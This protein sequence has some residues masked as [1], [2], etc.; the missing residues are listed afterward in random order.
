MRFLTPATLPSL[1][2]DPASGVAGD[3]YFNTTDNVQRIYT[4]TGWSYANELVMPYVFSGTLA[5]KTGVLRLY[6]NSD[7]A[8][9][10]Y[11]SDVYVS[12]A[13]TG[14]SA[15][16]GVRKN[17][18]AASITL[19]VAA[20]GNSASSTTKLSVAVGDYLTVD[21]S[22]VGSTVAGSDAQ[23]TILAAT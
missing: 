14:S 9:V 10:I 15:I 3:R 23:V 13:P 18:A 19:T 11:R 22:Q 16:F 1:A 5:T 12:T 17:G 20:A 4:G 8:W 6:N 2:S 7:S 21:L